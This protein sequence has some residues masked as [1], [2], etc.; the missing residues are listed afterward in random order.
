[1]LPMKLILALDFAFWC[2][3]AV[4]AVTTAVMTGVHLYNELNRRGHQVVLPR[5]LLFVTLASWM[6][7]VLF[8]VALGSP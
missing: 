8:F 1:M 7:V 4:C 3:V 2:A 5:S 6:V